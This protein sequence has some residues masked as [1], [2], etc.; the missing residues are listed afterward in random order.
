MAEQPAVAQARQRIVVG[1]RRAG[2]PPGACARRRPAAGR[3]SAAARRRARARATSTRSPRRSRRRRRSSASRPGTRG[4]RRR[5]GAGAARCRCR[6]RPGA[7][8]PSN[9]LAD[10]LLGGVAGD[11][12][13][14]AV[15]EQPAPVAVEQAGADRRAL[16][17]LVFASNVA[18][19]TRRE[20]LGPPARGDVEHHRHAAGHA[21]RARPPRRAVERSGPTSTITQCRCP[22]VQISRERVSPS[23]AERNSGSIVRHRSSGSAC[24]QRARPH[25]QRRGVAEALER[26]AGR[27]H[28]AQLGVEGQDQRLR[29]LAQRRLSRAVGARPQRIGPRLSRE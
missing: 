8:S 19:R 2:S 20:Q 25:A 16:E 27:P 10:Q 23:S 4:S 13:Q 26:L 17:A 12:A 14:R 6:R 7:R 3:R 21:A 5:A 15:D 9:A 24:R 18:A 11:V 29:Q 28:E 1:E 22:A